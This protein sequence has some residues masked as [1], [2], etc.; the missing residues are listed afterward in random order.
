MNII[1]IGAAG[2]I[3]SKLVDDLSGPSNHLFLGYNKNK[4]INSTADLQS[5]DARN[6]GSVSSFI[7]TGIKKFGS[8][9]AIVNLPG[10]LI[11]KPAHLTTEKEFEETININLKSAFAVVR[12]AGAILKN[13]SIVLISTAAASI[14]L[15]NHELIASAKAGVEGLARSAARTYA[16]KNIR[17]NTVS[18]GLVETPLASIITENPIIL[19]VSEKMYPLGRIG[20]PEDISRMILF[21]IRKENNWI[22]GQNFVVDGGLSK[23]K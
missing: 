2:G 18:P 11:L 22:T 4:P 19:K 8:V 16:R 13:C 15:A 5:L 7:K 9:D 17:I 23:T 10:N 1:I 14:G 21:L 12:S 6:F 3:G 20:K